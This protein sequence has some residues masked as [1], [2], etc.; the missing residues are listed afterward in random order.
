MKR[1][2]VIAA[3]IL[4]IAAV[5]RSEESKRRALAEELMVMMDM[6]ENIEKAFDMV[7]EMIPDQVRQYGDAGAEAATAAEKQ[8]Q[9]MMD[10][11]QK[12]MS[13]DKIKEDYINVYSE[14]F[15]E[16]EL[17][18]IV[19]FYKSPAGQSFIK[20]QPELMR[21]SME[22]SQKQMMELMPKI[23]ELNRKA[24]GAGAPG[25]QSRPVVPFGAY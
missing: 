2:L 21:R 25:G 8:A 13:W 9:D 6:K 23:Q 24:G 11:I 18:G 17:A 15:T 1:T 3:C 5:S 7:K 22:I 20:K 4:A 19:E 16:E 12:E 10:F 14:T